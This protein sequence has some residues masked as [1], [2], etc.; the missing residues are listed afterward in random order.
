MNIIPAI[1]LLNDQY[2]RLHRGRFDS[3]S[4]YGSDPV[5]LAKDYHRQG[6]NLVHVVDLNGAQIGKPF[7]NKLIEN[8]ITHSGCGVQA[9]GGLRSE[10]AI[11]KMFEQ[12]VSRVV[13]GSTA[14]DKPFFIEELL[15]EFGGSLFTLAFDVVQK[16]G[17][18]FVLSHGWQRQ[19]TWTLREVLDSYREYEGLNILCTDVDRDGTLEGPNLALYRYCVRHWPE[20]SIQASGGVASLRHLQQLASTGVSATVVGKALYDQKFTLEEAFRVIQNGDERRT[21]HVS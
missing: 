2:V 6:A 20:F 3:V 12:A 11:L 14:V 13:V 15:T 17:E 4:V 7:H 5:A 21:G 19:T 1:D 16:N 10:T 9:G 18:Y 8:L